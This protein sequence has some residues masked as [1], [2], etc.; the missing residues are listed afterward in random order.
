MNDS[1]CVQPLVR[2][3]W[4]AVEF[5]PEAWLRQAAAHLLPAVM[6]GCCGDAD[7]LNLSSVFGKVR[8]R[9]HANVAHA[10]NH[11][12][13]A[14]TTAAR[15][16][17][18]VGWSVE[19][20]ASAPIIQTFK[21]IKVLRLFLGAVVRLLSSRGRTRGVSPPRPR[22]LPPSSQPVSQPTANQPPRHHRRTGRRSSVG[23][24]G[25]RVCRA[26]LHKELPLR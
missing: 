6:A 13:A 21:S 15:H 14:A 17:D 24:C 5:L 2:V 25:T 22:A 10:T 11:K 1:H 12:T 8:H 16:G 4:Q 20:R 3:E 26:R 7:N 23:L 9:L 18:A 19:A